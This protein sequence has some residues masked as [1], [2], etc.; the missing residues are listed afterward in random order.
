[1]ADF[2]D[3][4]S[5]TWENCVVGQQ[6]LVDAVERTIELETPEKSYFLND[7]IATLLLPR[8]AARPAFLRSGDR[9]RPFL[10]PREEAADGDRGGS[11]AE[12]V[13]EPRSSGE[14]G[15]RVCRVRRR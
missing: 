8:R 7:D 15:C 12:P 1:M 2:E 5:P 6:N 4:N 13:R 14:R 10:E 3:A 9:Y 11:G